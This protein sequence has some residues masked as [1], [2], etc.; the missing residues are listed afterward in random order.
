MSGGDEIAAGLRDAI[1]LERRAAD[2]LKLASMLAALAFSATEEGHHFQAGAVWADAR[3]AALEWYHHAQPGHARAE[4]WLG[5][6]HAR[7]SVACVIARGHA[8]HAVD[9]TVGPQRGR[10]S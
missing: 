2:A 5:A 6:L 8:W 4:Q 3:T 7:G 1:E 9:L 10:D